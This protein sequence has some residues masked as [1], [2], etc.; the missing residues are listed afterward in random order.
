MAEV[1]LDAEIR[2]VIG[3]KSKHVRVEDKVPGVFYTTGEQNLNIQVLRTSLDPLI[4]TSRTNIIELRVPGSAKRCILRDVQFD[5]VTDT[6]VHFDLQGLREDTKLTLEIP[7]VLTGG[8][9]KGV[10]E[11]GMLQH[12]M[13]KLKVSCLPKDIPEKVEINVAELD[14]NRSVHVS[15]ITFPNVTIL[16]NPGSAVVAVVPPTVVKEAAPSEAP[17]E[18]PTEPEVLSKGKKAEEGEEEPAK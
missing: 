7:V 13:H 17:A 3:K 1:V 18:A 9:P 4:Y 15:E 14:I 11:G 2:N 10:R 5:P 8:I 16:E 12:I 6:P